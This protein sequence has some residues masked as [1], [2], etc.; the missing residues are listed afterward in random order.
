MNKTICRNGVVSGIKGNSLQITIIQ[1][2]ACGGCRARE[3]CNS[4]ESKER[5][6][7]VHVSNPS[8]YTI[9]QE[10]VLEGRHADARLASVVAYG[11]PLVVLIAVLIVCLQLQMS[12][13]LSSVVALAAVALYYVIVAM[14]MRGYLQRRL[15]FDIRTGV[16]ADM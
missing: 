4:S 12:E 9:G 3:L 5:H 10:L 8:D 7:S 2:T 15:S 13:A 6:V 16:S 11:L 14:F 1:S